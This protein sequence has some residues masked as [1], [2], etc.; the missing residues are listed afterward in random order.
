MK[1]DFV[2]LADEE[3]QA[4]LEV[5][6]RHVGVERI[7]AVLQGEIGFVKAIGFGV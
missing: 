6:Q 7:G 2:A 5:A 3:L 4:D 1:D